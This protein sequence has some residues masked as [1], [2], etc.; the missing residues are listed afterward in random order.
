MTK[1]QKLDIERWVELQKMINDKILYS[2]LKGT[3]SYSEGFHE[4]KR[5]VYLEIKRL[6]DGELIVSDDYSELLQK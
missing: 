2:G 3:D 4:G 1:Q 6:L 5:D